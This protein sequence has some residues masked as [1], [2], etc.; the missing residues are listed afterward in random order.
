MRLFLCAASCSSSEDLCF[1]FLDEDSI[2]LILNF[3]ISLHSNLLEGDLPGLF[4][5]LFV[6]LNIKGIVR[7]S[8]PLLGDFKN[9]LSKESAI[10]SG[11]N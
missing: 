8:S 2:S 1:K 4:N 6:G 10:C 3:N 5:G 7:V 9:G 11:P